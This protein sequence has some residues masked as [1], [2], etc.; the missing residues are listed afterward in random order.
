M[1][2]DRDIEAAED[3]AID[4]AHAVAR[5]VRAGDE[6]REIANTMFYA[7]SHFARKNAYAVL[8]ACDTLIEFLGPELPA[9]E[10]DSVTPTWTRMARDCEAWADC[11][12]PGQVAAMMIAC[13]KAM[14]GLDMGRNARNRQFVEHWNAMSPDDRKAFLDK[15]AKDKKP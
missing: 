9:P 14:R 10:G 13:L 7:G 4:G 15:V 8:V 2:G 11:A 6:M 3:A 1:I 5:G 12:P